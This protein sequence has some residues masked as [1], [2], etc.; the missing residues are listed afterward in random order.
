MFTSK[1]L[2]LALVAAVAVSGP[3]S[4]AAPAPSRVKIKK[5]TT[6]LRAP[7]AMGGEQ[8]QEYNAEKSVL[9]SQKRRSLIEDI[10]R[11]IRDSRDSEQAAELNLRLGKLYMEDYYANMSKAHQEFDAASTAYEKRKKGKAPTLDTSEAKTSLA[12][13]RSVYKD[14]LRRSPN[15]NRRDEVLYFL[16]VSSMDEG[17]MEEAMR[18][19]ERIVREVPKS[20]YFNDSLVQLA[21]YFFDQNK[22]RDAEAYYDRLIARKYVQLL[23]YATY[24]KGWCA[25]NRGAWS[26][27]INQFKWVI[28]F[29]DSDADSSALRIRGEA[30]RD[31]ALPFTDLKATD[32]AIAF[33]QAQGAPHFRSGL[34]NMASI[35]FEKGQF[36]ETIKLDEQLLAMDSNY[37][38]NA[39]YDLR[40]VDALRG[41]NRDDLAVARLVARL[42]NYVAQ[43]NW[44]E[45]NSSNPSVVQGAQKNYEELTRNFGVKTHAVAQQTKN[46]GLYNRAKL[47]Y[48]KYVEFFPATDNTAQVRFSL[49]EIEFRQQAYVLAAEN[50]YKVYEDPRGGKLRK[51]GIRYALSAL[52]RQLNLDRK[53]AGLTAINSHTTSKLAN[54]DDESLELVPYSS[55]ESR[56]FT[57]SDEYLKAFSTA[58]D[59]GD[60]LYEQ[61]YLR[62]THHDFNDAFKCFWTLVQKYPAHETSI[63]SAY[64]ILDILNRRKEYPKL[65]AACQK[66]LETKEFKKPTFR[67]EVAD[68]LRKAELKRIAQF[69]EKGQFRE[70]ADNYVE[71]TKA[72]GTQDEALFEKALYNAAIDYTKAGLLLPAV[73]TQER[74]LR[75]FPKSKYRESMV[76]QVAKTYE[77]LANFDKS[78]RYFEEFAN[79]YPSN[80]QAKNA[81]RLAGT[82]LAGSGQADRAEQIFARFLRMYPTDAKLVERDLL[83]LYESQN[84]TEKTFRYYLNAR[85]ARGVAFSEYLAYT[86]AAAEVAAGKSGHL[87]PQLMDEA[88]KVA[89]KYGDQIRKSPKGVE[90]LA[91]VRFWWVSQREALFQHYKLALPQATLEANLKRKLLL[92]QELEREYGKIAALG[93]AEWG[94]GAIYKTAAVYRHMAES[95][96]TA[97]VPA[98]LNAEA[99]EQYRGELK[100]QMIEPFNEK[101]K[102]F[103]ASCLDKSQEYNVMSAWTSQCYGLASELDPARYPRVRT[104]YLPPMTLALQIPPKDSKTEMGSLKRFAYPFYSSSLFSGTRQL[105]SMAPLDL[106]LIYDL[107]RGN[108]GQASSPNAANYEAL[109][110][111]R[112]NVLKSNYDSE[113]PD[114]LRKGASF[115]FLNLMRLVS[116]SRAIPMIETAIQHDPENTA[117][118]N[119]LGLAYLESGKTQGANVAWL[120]LVARGQATAAV[121]NNLG[122]A[123]A[124]EGNES[125]A[126]T[127]FQES[128]KLPG[129]KESLINMG[130]LALKYRNGF[131]AKNFFKKALKLD[132]DDVTA[133]AGLAVASLQN[134]E[135]DDAKDML[136][137]LSRRYSKDPYLK[138]SLGY[139]LIDVEHE[140]EA[141]QKIVNEYMDAQSLDKDMTF[142]QLLLETRHRADAGGVE[143]DPID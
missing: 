121:W 77:T 98:E 40:V 51:E 88:R 49:A 101:A 125:Q 102:N 138:L 46:D 79:L 72:Y 45:I 135:V 122:V 66:F 38:K 133:Q 3:H 100:R 69:E 44:Y 58:K 7:T 71:Y 15:H 14:L 117:L 21:D 91:K 94:L 53:K 109:T 131:E 81:L 52:D 35:Y 140:M 4:L 128:M 74:F 105:A 137:D 6:V 142:R 54:K 116:A 23:P 50:Y 10:K 96:Q 59:A 2:L 18:S 37:P 36:S 73:E 97:P 118:V 89:D 48:E 56:F 70:A 107:S 141:A 75:R 27:A 61:A 62:Y 111:E 124:R 113:K 64:L 132:D 5:R 92:L 112:R 110:T 114:D 9:L 126:I 87:P 11:F 99:L 93:N 20:K 41:M 78:G 120:S 85:A 119:L 28:S 104:F 108:D 33:F 139:F 80:A 130:F 55:T 60:V 26:E 95:I 136:A 1:R 86:M 19:F 32:D 29:A 115:S 134:R 83:S 63:S 84:A 127:Y 43:S 82:Y 68:I 65:I 57:I 67:S 13:A 17:K 90:A 34:E 143:T 22:F 24:K 47:I 30:M 42:P 123:A 25:H 106:P 76:L 31:I 39:D 16:A 103:A 12:K 129:A 8:E